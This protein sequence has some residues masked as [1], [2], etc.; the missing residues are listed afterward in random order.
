MNYTQCGGWHVIIIS[1]YLTSLQLLNVC[2]QSVQQA[3]TK[4]RE[5]VEHMAD[6]QKDKFIW[7]DQH[8]KAFM[9]LKTIW[10]SAQVLRYP[11]FSHPFEL[12]TDVFV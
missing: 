6:H 3:L 5:K 12:E 7:A 10:T 2:S 8:Q 4:K 9:F 11:D 1:S